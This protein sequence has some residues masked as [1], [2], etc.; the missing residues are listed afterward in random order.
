MA[1]DWNMPPR[2]KGCLACERVFEPG[3]AFEV[4]LY[5]AA[6]GYERRDYCLGC[7]PADENDALGV[8]KTRRPLPA[9]KKVQPFDREAIYSFFVR[10]DPD[11]PAKTQFRFVL[12][13]LLWRKKVLKFERSSGEAP[14]ETWHFSVPR[15][16][17]LHD[18]PRPELDEDRI[19]QLSNQLESLITGEPAK[20]AVIPA[21]PELESKTESE[22]ELE[23]ETE[24]EPDAERAQ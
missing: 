4:R 3:E 9:G 24:R 13:L 7:R 5:E 23:S 20:L 2:A 16:G 19:E 10:L 1:T 15:T 22:T 18:V 21:E 8:W 14:R 6:D 17:E 12:A 11:D